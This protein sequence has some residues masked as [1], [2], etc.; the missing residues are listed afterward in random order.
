MTKIRIPREIA[1][2]RIP[3]KVRRAGARLPDATAPAATAAVALAIV[4]G[5]F[6]G[7]RWLRGS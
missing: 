6:A 4:A 7:K 2:I 1:G 3:R 5:L